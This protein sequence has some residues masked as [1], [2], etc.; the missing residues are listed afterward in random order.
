MPTEIHDVEKF[1]QIAQQ[2]EY[3][4]I[5][6]LKKTVKLKIHTPRRLYTLK[7]NPTKAEEVIKKLACE[8]REV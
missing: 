2:A 1:I 4:A 8:I 3:C 7:I 6:R 5:K